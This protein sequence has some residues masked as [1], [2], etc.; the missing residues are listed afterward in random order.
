M[1][2]TKP[3]F[4]NKVQNNAEMAYTMKGEQRAGRGGG[5]GTQGEG[6]GL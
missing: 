4:H 3:R 1:L 2:W 6:K 5:G